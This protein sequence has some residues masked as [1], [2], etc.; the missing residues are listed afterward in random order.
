MQNKQ[1]KVQTSLRVDKQSLQEAKEILEKVGM[2]FSEAVNIFTKMIVY[3]KGL[4]FDVKI[5]SNDLTNKVKSALKEV[6]QVE[7][8]A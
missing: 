7:K 4:P 6:E 2:N 3:H 1:I 8:T 5:P